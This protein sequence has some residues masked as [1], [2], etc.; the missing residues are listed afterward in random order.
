M[1]ISKIN[2]AKH[3]NHLR[4]YQ[5]KRANPSYRPSDQGNPS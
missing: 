4:D 1:N 2:I 3:Y 5:G